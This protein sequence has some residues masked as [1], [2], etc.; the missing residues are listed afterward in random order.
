MSQGSDTSTGLP[1]S[2][3]VAEVADVK[4]AGCL[5]IQAE[6]RSV[7][8]FSS[9]GQI[10]AVDNRCPHMGFPLHRGTVCDRV[11]ATDEAQGFHEGPGDAN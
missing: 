8:L 4:S 3:R 5:V 7:A 11:A 10:Y 1:H 2:V 6:G 9:G